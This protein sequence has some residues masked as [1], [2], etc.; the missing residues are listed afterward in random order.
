MEMNCEVNNQPIRKYVFDDIPNDL[1]ILSEKLKMIYVLVFL[2][3]QI[4]Q[5]CNL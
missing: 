4:S 3:M 2:E 5:G 1:T